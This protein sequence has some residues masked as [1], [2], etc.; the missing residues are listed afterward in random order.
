MNKHGQGRPGC[1]VCTPTFLCPR[2]YPFVEKQRQEERAQNNKLEGVMHDISIKLIVEERREKAARGEKPFR[3][4]GT[5][6]PVKDLGRALKVERGYGYLDEMGRARNC[7]D[8]E[9]DFSRPPVDS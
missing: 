5:L 7:D 3:C 1:P 9:V 8:M 2:C 4:N 6:Y